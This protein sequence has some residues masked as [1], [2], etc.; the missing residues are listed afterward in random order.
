MKFSQRMVSSCFL[1][2]HISLE[3]VGDSSDTVLKQGAEAVAKRMEDMTAELK[4]IMAYTGV[5]D[6]RN[7]DAGV[8][9]RV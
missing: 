9:H 6:V 4:G 7:F 5:K 8:V 3:N 2:W 1:S